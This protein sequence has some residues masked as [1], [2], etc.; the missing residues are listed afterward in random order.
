M[1]LRHPTIYLAIATFLISAYLVNNNFMFLQVEGESMAPNIPSKT[2]VLALKIKPEEKLNK[3]DVYI[4]KGNDTK[5]LIK[6]LVGTSLERVWLN[7]GKI[8]VNQSQAP[9]I[10]IVPDFLPLDCQYTKIYEV[11]QDEHFFLGD[12][13][14]F[15]SDSRDWGTVK[16]DK[17]LAK[18]I[19]YLK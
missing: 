10:P 14:C 18:P 15:S 16:K 8:F 11:P 9:I 1:P 17:I 5:P 3:Y 2:F 19:F 13:I 7:N 12:N 4:L 6:R